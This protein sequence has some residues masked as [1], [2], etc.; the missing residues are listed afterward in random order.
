MNNTELKAYIDGLIPDNS[1]REISAEDLRNTLYSLLQ[2]SNSFGDFVSSDAQGNVSL[3]SGVWTPLVCDAL[4]PQTSTAGE[5]YYLTGDLWE[6][7]RIQLTELPEDSNIFVRFDFRY[8]ALSPNTEFDVKLVFRD[9]LDSI[10]FEQIIDHQYFKIAETRN[11]IQ[12]YI[13]FR[14]PAVEDGTV[15][16]QMK[17]DTNAEGRLNGLLIGY[18]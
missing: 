11:L 6:S 9:S 2:V 7:N 12:T 18:A 17:A 4:D 16:V 15:E 8:S 14:G 13:F 3:S 5:P 10:V 1:N